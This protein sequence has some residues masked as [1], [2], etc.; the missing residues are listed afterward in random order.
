MNEFSAVSKLRL[1][2]CDERLKRLMYEVIKV[3]D[4]SI[5][6][7]HRPQAEQGEAFRTG[8]SK[9]NWP[10]SAHN[11]APSRA[12]DVV[13]YPVE[14]PDLSV[15]LARVKAGDFSAVDQYARALGR[16]YMFVG[17]VRG[18]A[19]QMGIKVRCG[20]DWDGDMEVKDQ[21]FHDLPHVELAE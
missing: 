4:C 3:A 5:T 8:R 10:D 13:P 14:W 2:T 18:V 20:A 19:A 17:V 11:A 21:S 12:V 9:V 1:D 16:W 6:C 7:G 15:T